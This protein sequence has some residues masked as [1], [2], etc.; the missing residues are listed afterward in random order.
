MLRTYLRMRQAPQAENCCLEDFG[1]PA[2]RRGYGA[3]AADALLGADE[4]ARGDIMVGVVGEGE[5]DDE[6]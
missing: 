1:W 6:I 4:D 5:G 2:A 3:L